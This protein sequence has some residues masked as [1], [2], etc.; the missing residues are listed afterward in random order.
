MSLHSTE[1]VEAMFKAHNGVAVTYGGVTTYGH[2]RHVPV[3]AFDDPGILVSEPTVTIPSGGLPSIGLDDE[4]GKAEGIGED[5]QV[6]DFV[7]TVRAIEP[8]SAQG[9]IRVFL[10][11]RR[12]NSG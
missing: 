6:G 12:T 8:G 10:T 11:N 2:F 1:L 7:W 5:I 9:E 3:G 4:K